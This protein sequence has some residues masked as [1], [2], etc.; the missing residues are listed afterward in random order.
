MIQDLF[1]KTLSISQPAP[2]IPQATKNDLIFQQFSCPPIIPG[3]KED[4]RMW[5]VVN[6]KMDAV[7]GADNCKKNLRQGNY[8]IEVVLDYLKKAWDH[9]TWNADELLALKLERI[10]QCF[11]GEPFSSTFNDV[12][13]DTNNTLFKSQQNLVP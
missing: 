10:Y 7:F 4:E 12:I 6:K 13:S 2:Q 5:F 11:E 8:G 3:N 9:P 1:T